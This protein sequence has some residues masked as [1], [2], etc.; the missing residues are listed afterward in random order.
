MLKKIIT[1]PLI[2]VDEIKPSFEE[3][4]EENENISTSQILK[5][6]N[7]LDLKSSQAILIG[8]DKITAKSLKL[9]VNLKKLK[10]WPFGNKNF[11]MWKN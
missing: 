3:P 7:S 4:V 11:K 9:V 2:N 6:K 8:L 1:S 10:I 5:E